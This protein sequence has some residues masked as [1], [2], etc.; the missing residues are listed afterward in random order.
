MAHV[1]RHSCFS[2][3]QD[4]EMMCQK[5]RRQKT[6]RRVRQEEREKI[7]ALT[8]KKLRNFSYFL[9]KKFLFKGSVSQRYAIKLHILW[10]NYKGCFLKRTFVNE[11]RKCKKLSNKLADR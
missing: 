7:I 5:K 6:E 1:T 2:E 4:T 10:Q 8:K 9:F 3:C 11:N